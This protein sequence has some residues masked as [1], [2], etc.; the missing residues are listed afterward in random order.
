MNE[1]TFD[2]Y[3]TNNIKFIKF[4]ISHLFIF[5]FNKKM[6]FFAQNSKIQMIEMNQNIF[7]K[8]SFLLK[9]FSFSKG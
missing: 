6:H 9:I 1:K 8:N 7:P 3:K 4:T 5:D 2:E